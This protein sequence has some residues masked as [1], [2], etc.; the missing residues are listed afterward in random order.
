MIF[1]G[2]RSILERTCNCK[3]FWLRWCLSIWKTH[4]KTWER[5]TCSGGV[6][7][8]I[9]FEKIV[10][11]VVWIQTKIKLFFVIFNWIFHDDE[12]VFGTIHWHD[13]KEHDLSFV[14]I[15][16][17][18]K[19]LENSMSCNIFK[20]CFFGFW[21]SSPEADGLAAVAHVWMHEHCKKCLWATFHLCV[22][23]CST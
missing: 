16:F 1:K 18:R 7:F 19:N 8:F 12:I 20:I 3:G 2:S 17:S 21:K 6:H 4:L 9:H 5:V 13:R 11:S 23:H 10:A 15:K 14:L 22:D